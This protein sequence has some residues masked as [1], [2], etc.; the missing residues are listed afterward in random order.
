[1]LHLK[2]LSKDFAGNPLFTDI[3]WHLKK[4]ERVAL[5]GENGAGKSTLMKIIAGLTEPSSGEI[6]FARGARA[7]YLPQDGIVTSGCQLFHEARSA[8]GELLAMEQELHQLGQELE[9]FSH[10]SPEHDQLLQRYGELQEQFR[11]RGGYTMESEIGTVLKGLGFSQDDWYRDCGEFSG[12]WQMRIA[13]ARLLLQR[14]DVLLLDEPTNHLDIEARNWLEEYLC[15]YPGSVIL[16]SHDRF[17]MDQVCSR[18]AEVWN[19]TISDYHCIYSRYLVQREER[20]S[21]LREAKRIQDEEVEKVEDFIRRFRYQANKASLVQSRI[22]HLEKVERIVIPPERKRIRFHFPDAPKSGKI[23]MELKGLT[24]AYDR[25]VVLDRINLV[26]EKGER[27]ALVGHNGAGKSTLMSVLAGATF[28]DGQRIMGHNV[29][30]DYFAQDQANVLDSS[31]S[32]W[33]ELYADAPYDMVPKLRDILGAFLF[34]GDDINKKVGVLSGGERN[35]LAL[36]KMLLRPSNLLLMDEPTN[37][38]DLFS[39]E[40]LLDALRSFDGTLVFVSHDRYF[41]NGLATRIVEVEGGILTEYFGD[42]EYYLEKKAGEQRAIPIAQ[43]RTSGAE[44]RVASGEPAPL[45]VFE[46]AERLRDREEQKRQKREDE[47]RQKLMVETEKKI[48]RTESSIA[49]LEEDMAQPGFF[50]DPER[51]KEAGERHAALNEQL[52]Q[53]Y[54][55]WE[56]LSG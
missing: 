23:V 50:D 36:A 27:V 31:R 3:S 4:G 5:V 24:K 53:L 2:Q 28:Q 56:G 40:V 26:I 1:M 54:A 14:P 22:K 17:F 7:S 35:R 34:S 30:M 20:V 9:R 25:H 42:Y 41:V 13:L 19:H 46:K 6:Q 47:K 38:L 15:S 45:P 10:D 44:T 48:A 37:H 51:G 43:P 32:A 33:D 52:E 8:F 29:S 12:G 21:A 39:K 49:L 18:V 11:H 55:E 16:V